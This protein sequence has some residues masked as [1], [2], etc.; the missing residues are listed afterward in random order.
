[1]TRRGPG[2]G[3]FGSAEISELD[4]SELGE[5]RVAESDLAMVLS[6]QDVMAPAKTT[7][8]GHSA[9]VLAGEN[10][11]AAFFKAG[12]QLEGHRV[13]AS[14]TWDGSGVAGPATES[15]ESSPPAGQ[16][17]PYK[18]RQSETR[19]RSCVPDRATPLPGRGPG[20]IRPDWIAPG[21][22]VLSG[23]SGSR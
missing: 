1:M 15:T 5:V 10:K 21:H 9:V 17:T 19:Q 11:W 6:E 3:T 12:G 14:Q 16:R 20:P 22:L 4:A 18:P 23:R 7:E 8:P 13:G 2:H